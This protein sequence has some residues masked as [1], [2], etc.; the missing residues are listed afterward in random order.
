M[1]LANGSRKALDL[2]LSYNKS[3]AYPRRKRQFGQLSEKHMVQKSACF[4]AFP[5]MLAGDLYGH[6]PDAYELAGEVDG[7]R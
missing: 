4:R 6:Q 1:P 3:Y 2:R 5:A 7:W